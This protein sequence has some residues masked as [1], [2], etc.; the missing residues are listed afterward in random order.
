MHNFFTLTDVYKIGHI[1]Q[2]PEG[3]TKVY[4]YLESRGSKEFEKCVFFGLQYIIKNYLTKT[5][6]YKDYEEF[7]E[8][9]KMANEGIEPSEIVKTR[10]RSLV[11]LGYF[12]LEIKSVP[13]GT[14]IELK[15]VLI[16]ITNTLPDFFWLVGYVE[17]IIL[18]I[19][20]P[21]TTASRVYKYREQNE[22]FWHKTV[23]DDKLT[24]SKYSVIDFGT[25]GNSSEESAVI[26]SLAFMTLFSGSDCFPVLNGAIKYYG[27]QKGDTEFMRTAPATEHSV[28]CA[29]GKDNEIDAFKRMFELYPTRRVCI[30]SDTYNLWKVFTEFITEL[31]DIILS[32]DQ[33]TSFR[34]D[35]GDPYLIITG[36]QSKEQD[37]P[38]YFGCMKLLDMVF[39]STINNKGYKVLNKVRIMYGDG[40]TIERYTNILK[41]MEIMGYSAEN[42]A[43]GVGSILFYANRDTLQF[44]IKATC[45]VIN[46]EERQIKKDPITDHSKKSKTGYLKLVYSDDETNN[47]VYF[48]H[49]KMSSD[50]EQCSLLKTVYRDGLL[51]ID[52]NLYTVK[53]RLDS[54]FNVK[55]IKEIV[56]IIGNDCSGKTTICKEI[57]E[58]FKNGSE[59]YPIERSCITLPGFEQVK[60]KVNP[61]ELDNI[62]HMH[63]FNKRPSIKR[64]IIVSDVKLPVKYVII[65]ANVNVLLS[66]S[67]LR[68]AEQR[69]KYESEKAL[70]YYKRKYMEMSSYYGI[71]MISNNGITPINIVCDDLLSTLR[72]YNSYQSSRLELL[73][74]TCQNEEYLCP[75]INHI[76][77][78]FNLLHKN[79]VN[80]TFMSS[81]E[82]KYLYNCLLFEMAVRNDEFH[83]CSCIVFTGKFRCGISNRQPNLFGHG[84]ESVN[85]N[86][87]V[88]YY[89]ESAGLISLC[90]PND[91]HKNKEIIEKLIKYFDE[92]PFHEHDLSCENITKLKMY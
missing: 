30:V 43:V 89:L 57:L 25:R 29:F 48:T 75:K 2:F 69:D 51:L 16:S 26:H 76:I 91:V 54:H 36:D 6:T 74:T 62:L 79:P 88:N 61:S 9:Y 42:L 50:E 84:P 11:E 80:Y 24:N 4:S 85:L 33:I 60:L 8:F 37:T 65:D 46:G 15:N 66:R 20:S 86:N 82:L 83:P 28:M 73:Q 27:I 17:V 52:E 70:K 10:L 3:C 19:W 18:K 12:P 63:T 90:Q 45:V 35:S 87:V 21:I 14:V 44:A 55:R 59:I 34:P 78:M 23:D 13:E 32:R 92:H 58:R 39:G 31:R 64:S 72:N 7:V 1:D 5:P 47:D 71:P 81:N 38:E 49:D 40:M 41:Q 68:P 77:T 67:Q 53:S 56:C 22:L